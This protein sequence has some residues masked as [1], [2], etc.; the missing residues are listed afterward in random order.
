M[1]RN[2]LK[3]LICIMLSS[4]DDKERQKYALILRVKSIECLISFGGIYNRK[5]YIPKETSEHDQ[6]RKNLIENGGLLALIY[7]YFKNEEEKI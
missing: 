4:L 5:L 7:I 3:A 1:S 2:I 6:A